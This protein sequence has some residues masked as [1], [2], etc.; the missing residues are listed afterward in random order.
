MQKYSISETSSISITPVQ[1]SKTQ[2]DAKMGTTPS[3][4]PILKTLPKKSVK[5]RRQKIEEK[6]R[7]QRSIKEVMKENSRNKKNA[8]PVPV[9]EKKED[10][11]LNDFMEEFR[12][13][14]DNQDR[15]LDKSNRKM[16]NMGLK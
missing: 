3:P 1:K 14:F 6:F 8:K 12:S 2:D 9:K 4:Q 15:K 16:D 11:L 5:E 13:R 7:L 10:I